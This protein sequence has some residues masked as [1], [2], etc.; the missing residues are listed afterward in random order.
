MSQQR[1]LVTKKASGTPGCI[2]EIVASRSREVILLLLYSAP[3]R[4]HLEYCVQFWLPQ[5]KK[6]RNLL[7]GI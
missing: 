2:S 3:M 6:D 7:E 1:A 4:P 5:V